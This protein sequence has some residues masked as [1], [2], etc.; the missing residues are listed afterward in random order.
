MEAMEN[1]LRSP[2]SVPSPRFLP[3]GALGALVEKVKAIPT[4]GRLSAAVEDQSQVI[5]GDIFWALRKFVINL[6]ALSIATHLKRIGV[7]TVDAYYPI[8]RGK[9]IEEPYDLIGLSCSEVN[10]PVCLDRIREL[11]AK[12][13]KLP[14]ILVGGPGIANW[15]KW[16]LG[17]GADGVILGDGQYPLTELIGMLLELHR[18][19]S[20]TLRGAFEKLRVAGS[21]SEVRDLAFVE[22]TGE[23]KRNDQQGL[24]QDL[25]EYDPV[26]YSLI[27]GFTKASVK[28]VHHSSGCVYHCDFCSSVVNQRNCYR[29]VT[30]NRLLDDMEQAQREGYSEVFLAS[31]LLLPGSTEYNRK[32]LQEVAEGR[33]QR[34]IKT[35]MSSQT[36]VSSLHNL[37]FKNVGTKEEPKWEYD[38][39]G[40]RLLR[41]AGVKRWSLGVEAFSEEERARLGK[42]PRQ[43]GCDTI[44]TI[45]AL[46]QGGI[47]V[48][49]MMMVHEDT[50]YERAIE[51][52]RILTDIGVCSAQFFHPTPMPQTQ[53][54]KDLFDRGDTVLG[55]VGGEPISAARFTGEYVVA[56]KSPERASR[57][58]EA[59]YD[60]FTSYGNMWRDLMH[61]RS[62]NALL[63]LGTKVLV[64]GR[65][66]LSPQ[67]YE[68][69]YNILKGNYTYR[70][71]SEPLEPGAPLSAAGRMRLSFKLARL[72]RE[73]RK[74]ARLVGAR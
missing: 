74:Q 48:H 52:G 24:V 73:R 46:T 3:S 6:G 7:G 33:K 54:G 59:C 19:G 42:D 67:Y 30:V 10:V 60:S 15:W 68:Y 32:M 34:R 17:A 38:P 41:A 18:E 63:K 36:T 58:I 40:I 23:L 51:I 62:Y 4:I 5:F 65:R 49:A 29:R 69:M 12:L 53:W 71:K 37:L 44:R 43:S 21:L 70:H 55:T 72:L 57:I 1:S 56:A 2:Q 31:D 13:G 50:P 39:E 25:D 27:K 61:G 28:C 9:K 14:L 22:P 47:P 45:A 20:L 11:R 16:H 64:L 35:K 26:D 8:M 66:Y